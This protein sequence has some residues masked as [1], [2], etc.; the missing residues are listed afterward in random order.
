[1]EQLDF[2]KSL[3]DEISDGVYFVNS[4]RVITYWNKAA[5]ELSGYTAQEVIGR[6]CS[7]D[8]LV[9]IDDK[10]TSLC[11]MGCPLAATIEDAM[12]HEAH[13]FLKHKN[14]HRVPVYVR[15]KPLRD[16]ND[17]VIGGV[18]TFSDDSFEI[19]LKDR[20]TD[21]ERKSLI[22]SLTGVGN[23]RF[24]DITLSSRLNE[25]KRY[26]W[27]FGVIFIDIDD[28]KKVN[29]TYGHNTGDEVLK[30][31]TR[32]TA[33]IIREPETS[34]FRWGGEEFL[35]VATNCD[36]EKLFAMAERLRLLAA[37][38]SVAQGAEIVRF[39]VSAGVTLAQTADDAKKIIARVDALLYQAKNAGKNCCRIDSK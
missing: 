12:P 2:Y 6:H 14:G 7:D 13:I 32:T 24:A 29:D 8:I 27:V 30:V 23:R 37:N 31:L 10:G 9:H 34:I 16:E 25:L 22:D 19:A 11:L 26:G 17:N 39:T 38:S 33:G 28:F 36:A 5:E 4:D 1:L 15:V 35:V 18:E 3:L 21:L 20:V